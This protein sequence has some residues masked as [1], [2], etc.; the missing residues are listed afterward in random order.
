MLRCRVP[1][2]RSRSRISCRTSETGFP[3]RPATRAERTSRGASMRTLKH[4]IPRLARSQGWSRPSTTTFCRFAAG[5]STSAATAAS[6]FWSTSLWAS[7]YAPNRSSVIPRSAASFR[8]IAPAEISS[9]LWACANASATVVLPLPGGPLIA[10]IIDRLPG[11]LRRR[12]LREDP[13]LLELLPKADVLQDALEDLAE[14]NREERVQEDP[15]R[16]HVDREEV[17]GRR[18][19]D[20]EREVAL[21][22]ERDVD[23]QADPGEDHDEKEHRVRHRL[24]R[25]ELD[26]CVFRHVLPLAGPELLDLALIPLP[27]RLHGLLAER[28]QQEV[29]LRHPRPGGDEVAEH[30]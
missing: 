3:S 17:R 10:R 30:G 24:Q 9:Q 29:H 2:D 28:A 27:S 21:L 26:V 6:S 1:S 22:H 4:G 11:L 25:D 15:A 19:G 8:K 14:R 20:R 7:A 12:E 5:R 23:E 13:E 16:E 18:P